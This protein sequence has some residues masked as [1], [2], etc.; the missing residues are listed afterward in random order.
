MHWSDKRPSVYRVEPKHGQVMA[1]M[2]PRSVEFF[3]LT[4]H[5]PYFVYDFSAPLTL[6]SCADAIEIDR[7]KAPYYVPD[8][9]YETNFRS[10]GTL[11]DSSTRNLRFEF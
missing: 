11:E 8:S 7:T 5:G 1:S 3:S 2:K 10:G 6:A 9:G 4:S